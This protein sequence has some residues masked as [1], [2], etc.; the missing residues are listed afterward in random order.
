ME[1]QCLIRAPNW[2]RKDTSQKPAMEKS[3]WKCITFYVFFL[4]I[5]FLLSYS[6]KDF[7]WPGCLP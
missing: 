3:M 2:S 4:L 5:L 7:D 1:P 6:N